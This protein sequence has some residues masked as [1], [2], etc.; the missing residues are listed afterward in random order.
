[1]KGKVNGSISSSEFEDKVG[2]GVDERIIVINIVS[3]YYILEKIKFILFFFLVFY[4][5]I[6][7]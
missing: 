6:L 2:E 3:I 5:Y 4:W 7:R 1:M